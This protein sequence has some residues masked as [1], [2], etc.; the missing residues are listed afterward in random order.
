MTAEKI[1]TYIACSQQYQVKVITKAL[2]AIPQMQVV[3]TTNNC[4]ELLE[5][6]SECTKHPQ[7][8]FISMK[9]TCGDALLTTTLLRNILPTTKIIGVDDE[10]T[11]ELVVN[12]LAEGS[13]ACICLDSFEQQQNWHHKTYVAFDCINVTLQKIVYNN[14]CYIDPNFRV[15]ETNIQL[16][17]S[18]HKIIN[19]QYSKLSKPEVILLQLNVLGINQEKM[20]RLVHMSVPTIKRKF[21]N[22]YTAFGVT[23]PKELAT[24]CISLGIVKLNLFY[25]KTI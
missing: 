8:I 16:I 18:T 19:K 11:E 17:N 6:L 10:A 22:L 14:L 4:K 25:S 1:T 3:Y 7:V 5:T 12:F 9:M 20:E 13:N 15:V 24:T 21:K 23:N 2:Q